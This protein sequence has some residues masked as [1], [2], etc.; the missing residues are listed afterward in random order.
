MLIYYVSTLSSITGNKKK[1][2][3][4]KNHFCSLQWSKVKVPQLNE[5]RYSTV[6][7]IP[8]YSKAIA[9]F[10]ALQLQVL[11]DGMKASTLNTLLLFLKKF[12]FNV[13][14]PQF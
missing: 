5:Y 7:Q 6:Q 11:Q 3:T 1:Q 10:N 14:R 8:D 12:D 2:K 13:I 9:Y 4:E